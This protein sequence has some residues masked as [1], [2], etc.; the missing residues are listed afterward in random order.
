M[1]A[2]VAFSKATCLVDT[3]ALQRSIRKTAQIVGAGY[4]RQSIITDVEHAHINEY[5]YKPFLR[6][7]KHS[8]LN[9]LDV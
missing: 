3:G 7:A 8:I 6:P 9:S 5:V 1:D 2:G 4:I